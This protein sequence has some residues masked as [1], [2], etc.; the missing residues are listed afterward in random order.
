MAAEYGRSS[1]LHDVWVGLCTHSV[2]L[3]GAW[4][5]RL[6]LVSRGAEPA[7]GEILPARA[8]SECSMAGGAGRAGRGARGRQG[9]RAER[10][11]RPSA[12]AAPR[13]APAFSDTPEPEP[14]TLYLLS[15]SSTVTF[16]SLSLKNRY[17]AL[18]ESSDA[19]RALVCRST[20]GLAHLLDVSRH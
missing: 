3:G 17:L 16:M 18:V 9:P 1:I 7:P 12:A 6:A 8:S 19:L 2:G 4:S 14:P 5:R 20:F 11:R 10:S 15:G 13:G